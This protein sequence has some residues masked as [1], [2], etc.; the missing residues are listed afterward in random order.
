VNTIDKRMMSIEEL[1]EIMMEED[2]TSWRLSYTRNET[3]FTLLLLCLEVC[4]FFEY[5]A[6]WLGQLP[7]AIVSR[8]MMLLFMRMLYYF[9]NRREHRRDLDTLLLI[10]A[11]QELLALCL[12]REAIFS[13][14][15]FAFVYFPIS[16]FVYVHHW[17]TLCNGLGSF[18]QQQRQYSNRTENGTGRQM[19]WLYTLDTIEWLLPATTRQS[20]V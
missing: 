9:R 14:Y 19:W 7:T 11:F 4:L 15:M 20:I 12:W 3:L 16:G 2:S 10:M 1:S 6:F 18:L 13:L 8:L 5:A 17:Q